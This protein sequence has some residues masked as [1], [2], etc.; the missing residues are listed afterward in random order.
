MRAKG[1]NSTEALIQEMM[2]A[3][4]PDSWQKDAACREMQ[5]DIFFPDAKEDGKEE[6]ARK[7]EIALGVCKY[8]PVREQCLELAVSTKTKF[9]IFG[10]QTE[11]E[12]KR[13][14]TNQ[15]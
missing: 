3:A 12:R 9:G 1:R 5:Q 15:R 13:N 2:S 4:Q 14:A 11:Q 8:C 10:G 6:A 7:E